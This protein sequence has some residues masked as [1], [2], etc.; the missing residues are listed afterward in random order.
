MERSSGTSWGLVGD[1]AYQKGHTGTLQ[2]DNIAEP[3]A[4]FMPDG[5]KYLIYP[6]LNGAKTIKLN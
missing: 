2:L 5:G 1:A 6:I 4:E 3:Q